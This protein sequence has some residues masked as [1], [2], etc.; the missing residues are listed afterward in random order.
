MCH[1][2]NSIEHGIWHT[3]VVLTDTYDKVYMAL[4]HIRVQRIEA[5]L[6]IE[7]MV[8]YC[9]VIG[10]NGIDVDNVMNMTT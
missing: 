5:H 9:L 4:V 2:R 6:C 1:H 8:L 10:C 7:A 3:K